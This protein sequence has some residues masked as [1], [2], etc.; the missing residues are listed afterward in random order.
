MISPFQ[1]SDKKKNA[2]FCLIA[3][4]IANRINDINKMTSS[5]P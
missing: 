2:G 3:L 1:L 5:H 4:W